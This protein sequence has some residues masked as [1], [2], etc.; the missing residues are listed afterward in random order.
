MSKHTITEQFIRERVAARAGGRL[1]YDDHPKA[2]RGFALKVSAAGTATF[3]LNYFAKGKERRAK[4]GDHGA[5]GGQLSITAARIRASQ[6]RSI[7]DA[8]GDPLAD[9]D[10]S[11]AR[12][13]EDKAR[14]GESFAALLRAYVAHL[15]GMGKVSAREVETTFERRIFGHW[16]KLESMRADLVSVDDVMPAFHKLAKAGMWREGEKLRSYLRAAYTAARRARNDATMY[17][18]SEFKIKANPLADLDF[19]RPSGSST[20][21]PS[22][23]PLSEA[24]LSAYWN[25]IITDKTSHGPLLRL[26]L[27]TGGQRVEQL[28][29]LTKDDLD[30]DNKSIELRDVKGRRKNAYA[31]VVPLVPAAA[32]AIEEMCG[33]A[34]PYLVTAT[35]GETHIHDR[36][37]WEAVRKHAEAMLEAKE[38]D[39]PFSP[40]AIRMT[41]ETRL[42]A[43]GV[44]DEVLARLLSHGLG[45]VQ[46][47][48]Y[49]KHRYNDEKRAAL[50][51]LYAILVSTKIEKAH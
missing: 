6:M 14:A 46:A 7:I 17:A 8:G 36:T 27:L 9:K 49:N 42:A 5:L 16:P 12:A 25:R 47:R 24:Q 44:S 30:A 41:I 21:P 10:A 18:F 22:K 3:V 19:S 48:H 43:R 29:R 51:K 11:A 20:A 39:K 32:T 4:V 13:R 31:H 50:E 23:W 40:G 1:Y 15:R 45:T 2:P 26:H 38:V 33:D 37:M 28:V 35:R 34:G